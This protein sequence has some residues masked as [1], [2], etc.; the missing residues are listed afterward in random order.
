MMMTTNQKKQ[1]FW[2]KI[3]KNLLFLI[4]AIV[5]TACNEKSAFKIKSIKTKTGWGYTIACKDRIII[6]QSIIPVINKTK[7]F[8]TEEDALK[9]GNLVIEKLNKDLSPTVTKNDLILLKIKL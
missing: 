9:T 2:N 4:F 5:F 7:S 8:A 6:K 1:F 3:Q